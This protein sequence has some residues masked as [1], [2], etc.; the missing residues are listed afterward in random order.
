MRIALAEDFEVDVAQVIPRD[1]GE[2]ALLL[3]AGDE[4]VVVRFRERKT[5][6]RPIGLGVRGWDP[7]SRFGVIGAWKRR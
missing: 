2:V 4:A 5:D 7:E 3:V 6:V 1:D